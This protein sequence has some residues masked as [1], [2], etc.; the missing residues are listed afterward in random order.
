MNS[1][2]K[3]IN[4]RTKPENHNSSIKLKTAE[5]SD[6]NYILIQIVTGFQVNMSLIFS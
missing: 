1:G 4:S 2:S 3:N 5:I 6:I